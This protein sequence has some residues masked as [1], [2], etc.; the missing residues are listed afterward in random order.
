[1]EIKINFSARCSENDSAAQWLY[2]QPTGQDP[3]TTCICYAK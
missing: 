3:Y 1:M 2:L